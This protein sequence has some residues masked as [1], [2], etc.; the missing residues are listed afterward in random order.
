M[1]FSLHI[2]IHAEGSD[3]HDRR[4]I[5]AVVDKARTGLDTAKLLDYLHVKRFR[6]AAK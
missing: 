5:E 3:A 4:V 6:G 2:G 1:A